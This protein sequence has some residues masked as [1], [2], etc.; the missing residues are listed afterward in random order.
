MDMKTLTTK[1]SDEIT[2]ALPA[3]ND[4]EK[5]ELLKMELERKTPRKGVLDSLGYEP[6]KE[7]EPEDD[8][9][10]SMDFTQEFS[11]VHHKGYKHYFQN[12]KVFDRVSKKRIG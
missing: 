9:E 4:E 3:L 1:N 7:S 10:E 5:A 2:A 12:G 8:G 6:P 11:M